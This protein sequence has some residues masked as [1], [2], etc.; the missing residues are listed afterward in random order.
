MQPLLDLGQ[1]RGEE[2]AIHADRVATERNGAG[3]SDVLLD[4]R[5]RLGAGLLERD[6][7]RGDLVEQPRAG[8]H[9]DDDLVHVGQGLRRLMDDQVRTLRDDVEVVVGDQGRDLDDDVGPRVEAGHLEIHP[10]QHP[11]ER[12]VVG[13]R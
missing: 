10:H 11:V 8:V 2:A 12:T 3:R 9:V 13:P 1:V 6:G 7:R 5:E 4:E